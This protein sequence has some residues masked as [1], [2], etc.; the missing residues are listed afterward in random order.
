MLIN[1]SDI[2]FQEIACREYL[3]MGTID[4]VAITLAKPQ[5]HPSG[6]DYYCPYKILGKDWGYTHWS[7][8]IDEIQAI[9][10]A[11]RMINIELA[12][13][14]V[15]KQLKLLWGQEGDLGFPEWDLLSLNSFEAK[16]KFDNT[17]KD[18]NKRKLEKRIQFLRVQLEQ[19]FKNQYSPDKIAMR[20]RIKEVQKNPK[21][22]E[23]LHKK[24]K[25]EKN[26][27]DLP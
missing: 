6:R 11:L 16:L 25:K 7:I 18:E 22:L 20:E 27:S 1:E 12:T 24:N 26:G 23:K 3:V 19:Y 10:N 17:L 4:K 5:R 2:I 8:G 15:S 13:S 21:L 9:Q 14:K